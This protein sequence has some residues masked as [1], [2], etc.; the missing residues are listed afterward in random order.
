M[1]LFYRRLTLPKAPLLVSV[2]LVSLVLVQLPIQLSADEGGSE[3]KARGPIPLAVVEVNAD[4]E[5]VS[6]DLPGRVSAFRQ[7]QVR[8][9]VDSIIEQRVFEEGT[10][11]EAGQ[12]LFKIEDRSLRATHRARKAD[13]ANAVAAYNLSRQ[14]LKRYKKLLTLGAVS[15]QEYD[16]NAAQNQQSKAQVE[17]ARANLDLAKINLDYATVTAPISGRIDKALVTEGAL[18][19]SGSTQLANIEQI[20]KVYVDFTRS[21]SDAIRIRQATQAGRLAN[22][23]NNNIE[24]L[25]S[26]GSS[27]PQKG[28]LEFSSMEVD[29]A[30]G[31]ISLRAVVENPDSVLLPGMFVRVKVPVATTNNVVKVPQKAVTITPQGPQVYLIA[32]GQLKPQILELGPMTGDNWYVRSG[33]DAGARVVVS[34]TSILKTIPGARFVGMT[35]QEMQAAGM[36]PPKDQP[37]Q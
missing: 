11:V 24:I 34:D 18:T 7:A 19:T 31:A 8:A 25:F 12:L 35:L 27:Y 4:P 5:I 2:F 33:L 29:Q 16:T 28:K 22:T 13:V 30:T 17:Q 14:T 15:Q 32:D 10:K 36:V 21:S 37:Q 23:E 20:D 1:K 9:R 6:Q 26:D 3:E